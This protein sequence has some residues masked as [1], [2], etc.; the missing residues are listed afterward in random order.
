M[1]RPRSASATVKPPPPPDPTIS[2]IENAISLS[3]LSELGPNVFTNTRPQWQ[4]IGARGIYGG[5]VIAQC[6]LAAQLTVPP[7]FVVHSM[8]CYFVLAGNSNIPI[9]YHVDLVRSGRS[10]HTRTVQAKQRGNVIFTT[11]L[12]FTIPLSTKF[13]EGQ[14]VGRVVKH[15]PTFPSGVK[16]PEECENELQVIDRLV[17][18]GRIDEEQAELARARYGQ[19]PFEFR[20]VGVSPDLPQSPDTPINSVPP[21]EKVMRQWVR[22]KSPIK[23]PLF[24][25]PAL[26]YISDSWFIGTVGRVNPEARRDKVGMMVS[27]DHTI[28]FHAGEKTRLDEWLLLETRSSWAGEERGLVRMNVWTQSGELLAQCLQ[29]GMVRLKD[30]REGT[31]VQHAAAGTSTPKE[32]KESAKL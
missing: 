17:K 12:S 2:P 18:S 16:G 25:N 27:L 15:Q 28:H 23:D 24:Y 13:E 9:I 32:L 10:F 1:T 7:N 21:A 4:P 26:A 20:S 5:S 19:D 8:H 6:L 30:G 31:D 14:G 11:T 29:E 3:P 22:S